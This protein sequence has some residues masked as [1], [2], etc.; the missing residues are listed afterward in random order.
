MSVHSTISVVQ[1]F[2]LAFYIIIVFCC[3]IFLIDCVYYFDI[4]FRCIFWYWCMFCTNKFLYHLK[5]FFCCVSYRF[6]F[7]IRNCV[8]CVNDSFLFT[9]TLF[10][11]GALSISTTSFFVV[12]LEFN[13]GCEFFWLDYENWLCG[14]YCCFELWAKM[15]TQ[16]TYHSF[17]K[18]S[19]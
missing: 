13:L 14:D 5:I 12:S 7:I 3:R 2:L 16:P 4:E 1:Y 19:L 10:C 18:L 15:F 11:L 6:C 9:L 8:W 17:S